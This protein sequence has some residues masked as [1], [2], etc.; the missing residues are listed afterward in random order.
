M[1]E[2]SQLLEA[3]VSNYLINPNQATTR[4]CKERIWNSVRVIQG[5]HISMALCDPSKL[6][7]RLRCR[8]KTHIQV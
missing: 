4:K 2:M 1:D 5:Y 3:M 6:R 8:D 7:H